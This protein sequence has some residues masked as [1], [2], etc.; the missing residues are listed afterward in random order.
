M[1]DIE[2]ANAS[3]ALMQFVSLSHG[4]EGAC[5]THVI[6]THVVSCVAHV[7]CECG[8][9]ISDRCSQQR[10]VVKELLMLTPEFLL[11]SFSKYRGFNPLLWWCDI[12]TSQYHN[13][14]HESHH[15]N[16]SHKS[17]LHKVC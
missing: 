9:C 4:V 3:C 10:R 1:T 8:M 15:N 14:T 13:S 11:L 5:A 16:A 17:H 2:C 12:T 6:T 7:L